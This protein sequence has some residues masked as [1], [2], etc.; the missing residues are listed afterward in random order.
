MRVVLQRVK[1]A[2][3]VVDGKIVAEID[4]GFLLLVGFSNKDLEKKEDKKI[5][6][7]AKKIPELRIFSDENGKF[8]LS[9][10][11]VNGEILAVSQFTLYGDVKK[12]R[13]PNFQEAAP[14]NEAEK[15]FN[16]FVELLG[17]EMPNKVKKGIF[18]ANMEINLCNI[19]PVTL[20]LD[21]EKI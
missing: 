12:G 17:V 19:G 1:Y 3:V 7:L 2:N 18:G 9:L 16:E 15:L 11:D 10:K 5:K 13:R 6:K 14:Y 4:R 21:S 8:D 20:I